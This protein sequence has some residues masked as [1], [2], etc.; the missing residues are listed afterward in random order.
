[1]RAQDGMNALYQPD[2]LFDNRPFLFDKEKC[3]N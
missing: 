1:M 3:Y 2:K